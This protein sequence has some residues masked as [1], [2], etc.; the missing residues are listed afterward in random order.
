MMQLGVLFSCF[1]FPHAQHTYININMKHA[2]YSFPFFYQSV[3]ALFYFLP[4]WICKSASIWH[5]TGINSSSSS[6]SQSTHA[7]FVLKNA[8]VTIQKLGLC[9]VDDNIRK[10]EDAGLLKWINIHISAALYAKAMQ[11]K[12]QS[13][14]CHSISCISFAHA[15]PISLLH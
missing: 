3:Y 14:V 9:R 1:Y 11:I 12:W 10:Q 4:Y 5:S 15:P 6:L 8:S 7:K 2:R 13:N